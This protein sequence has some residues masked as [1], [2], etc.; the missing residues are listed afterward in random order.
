MNRESCPEERFV[1][2]RFNSESLE[3]WVEGQR[4]EES[5]F[6]RVLR[7]ERVLTRVTGLVGQLASSAV[8]ECVPDDFEWRLSFDSAGAI[9]VRFRDLQ[10]PDA[11]WSA[12]SDCDLTIVLLLLRQ[13]RW[14]ELRASRKT[15]GGDACMAG[16]VSA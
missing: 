6:E 4:I 11:E 13:T 10:Q 12:W 14:H 1:H 16:R 15:S 2:A 9:T 8:R 7:D 5:A 3:R